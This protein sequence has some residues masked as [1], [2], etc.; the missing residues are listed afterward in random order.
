MK[1]FWS[2]SMTVNKLDEPKKDKKEVVTRV[3][4]EPK[5][6]GTAKGSSKASRN[7]SAR[8]GHFLHERVFSSPERHPYLEKSWVH[9]TGE[10][11]NDKGEVRFRQDDLEFPEDWSLTAVNVVSSKY[12]KG[13]PGSTQREHSL[14]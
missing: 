7:G 10:I 14:K 9:R 3:L 2:S 8:S 6:A 12:F 13:I 11:V 4:F 1:G 5:P